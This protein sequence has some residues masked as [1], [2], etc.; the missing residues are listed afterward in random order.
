MN[1]TIIFPKLGEV[2]LE[3]QA[4]PEVTSGHVLV[5]TRTS[6]ISTGTELTMLSGDFPPDSLWATRWAQYPVTPGYSN[7]GEVVEVGEGA[8]ASLL[9]KRVATCGNHRLYNLIPAETVI[10]VPSAGIADSHAAFHTLSA[11]VMNGVRKAKLEWGE[12]VAVFG[13]GLLGQLA[14]RFAR[15]SGCRP[16]FGIDISDARLALLPEDSGIVRVNPNT[17]DLDAVINDRTRGRLVDAAF[18]VTGNA[19]LIAGQVG[20]IRRQGRLIILS[21]PRGDSAFNFCDLCH[22]PAISIIG[23]HTLSHPAHES[24]DNPWIVGRNIELFFDL[25]QSGEL[26]MAPLISHETGYDEGPAMFR[27]LLEDR[28]RSMGVILNW[29]GCA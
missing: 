29:E 2:V 20:H 7:I 21:S 5:K 22:Y 27:M 6:L 24:A 14:V 16:V 13:L 8:D 19:D 9:G 12:T 25:L 18:E 15:L 28:S 1:P 17:D 23:A 3:D 11:I 4:I 26:D 10:P